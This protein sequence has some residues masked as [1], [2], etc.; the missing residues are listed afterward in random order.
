MTN[1][2][3]LFFSLLLSELL[4]KRGYFSPIGKSKGYADFWT[5]AD[6]PENINRDFNIVALE[7]IKNSNLYKYAEKE[8]LVNFLYP[9]HVDE[10]G[11]NFTLIK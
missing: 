5:Y 7:A 10:Y 2:T 4:G 8:G 3:L 6:S 9:P 1:S 11:I